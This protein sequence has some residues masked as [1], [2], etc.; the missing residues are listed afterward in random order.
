LIYDTLQNFRLYSGISPF[1]SV[2]AEYLDRLSS[3]AFA[4]GRTGIRGDDAYVNLVSTKT[5]SR[6]EASFEFH[7]RYADIHIV[8]E[9]SERILVSNVGSMSLKNEFDP[10]A[11]YGLQEGSAEV[12][13]VLQP[14]MFC[15]CLPDDSHMPLVVVDKPG[16]LKK[17]IIKMAV[18]S[19][20]VSLD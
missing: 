20:G 8:L 1:A 9:G 4:E 17:I 5:R 7:R 15:I 11:D 13:L 2:V 12:D 19:A 18:Q 10:V 16:V 6:E 14:G 3:L